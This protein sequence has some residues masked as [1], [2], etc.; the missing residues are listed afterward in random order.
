MRFV[1]FCIILGGMAWSQDK[2]HLDPKQTV[3][4]EKCGECHKSE[5]AAWKEMRHYKSFFDLTQSQEARE[6]AQKMGLKR[7]KRESACLQCHFTSQMEGDVVKPIAGTSCESCHGAAQNWVNI[8][9]DYGGKDVK[10]ED[11]GPEHRKARI[12]KSLEAGMIRPENLY[13]V[14]QNC[15]QC[16]TVPHETLVNVGG[17]N[18]GSNFELVA[19]SQGEVRHNF[20]RSNDGK[21]NVKPEQAE[22]RLLYVLGQSLEL[23]YSLRGLAEA[24]QKNKYAVTMAKRVKRAQGRL[25]AIQ[26][27]VPH[28]LFEEMIKISGG[29]GLKLNNRDPLLKAADQVQ[30][31]AMKL[32]GTLG[33]LSA[34]DPLLPAVSDYKG[35]ALEQ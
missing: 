7:I 33:D 10:K 18:L 15:Y 21:S 30:A 1:A 25:K 3:G 26:E 2:L 9:N 12:Q 20:M 22:L 8:H 14:A 5:L 23:E 32:Q 17:H 24:T 16:H 34:V 19:Y 11:E 13:A 27:K 35:V 4:P 6:I 31:L 28:T 29:V